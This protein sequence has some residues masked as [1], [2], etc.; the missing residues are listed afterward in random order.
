[1]NRCDLQHHWD[2]I[3][4]AE[5]MTMEHQRSHRASLRPDLA[6]PDPGVHVGLVQLAI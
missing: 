5:I 6:T 4:D 2:G 3:S 1:M